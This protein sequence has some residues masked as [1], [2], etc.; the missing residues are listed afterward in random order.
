[1]KQPAPKPRAPRSI[2]LS[3]TKEQI[4]GIKSRQLALDT[5]EF[6]RR[7][8]EENLNN[9]LSGVVSGHGYDRTVTKMIDD[10]NLTLTIEVADEAELR[11]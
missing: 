8:A 6:N 9:F 2:T 4:A 5:A 7:V 11:K 1:M 3:I 10:D